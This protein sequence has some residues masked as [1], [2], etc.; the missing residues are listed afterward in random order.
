MQKS[1][2]W[3]YLTPARVLVIGFAALILIGGLLLSLPIATENGQGLRY[4][5]GVFTATSAVCVTGLVVVDTGDTFSLF[6]ELVVLALVQIGGLGFMT[7]AT[8]V[9]ILTGKKIGLKERLLIQESLNVSTLEGLVRLARNVVLVTVGIEMFFAIILSIRFS[10][11]FPVGRA[12]YY[13]IYHSITAFCN[14]GFDVMGGFKS[15]SDYV[16]DPTVNLAVCALIIMGGLGFIVLVDLGRYMKKRDR[17]SL[18]SKLTLIATAVLIVGGALGFYFLENQNP[19]TIGGLPSMGDKTLASLFASV[20][21]RTAGFA[22]LNYEVFTQGGLLWTIL[23][24]F[25]GAG[26]GST[27]GGIKTVTFVVILLYLWTV[28]SN[29]ENTVVFRRTISPRTIYKS[30]VIAVMATMLVV[31]AT[32]LLTVTENKEFLRLLFE[33]TSAFSTTGLSTNLSPV[34]S[35]PGRL[36]IIIMMYIGR[37]GPLTIALALAARQPDKANLK[38]PEENL[39]VG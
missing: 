19:Q 10:F 1:K 28:I 25:I 33:V 27:G 39:F 38:Y 23:L 24:M 13:G 18:H 16:G 14:A 21:S 20:T 31:F 12:I 11:D 15:L 9:T 37:L 6:G 26:P 3:R 17:L 29:K 8:F 36:I 22:T 2:I 4:L 30:L 32:F 35:D 34:L 7:V 5:D